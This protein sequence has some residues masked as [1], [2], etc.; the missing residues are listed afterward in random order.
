M[1]K[2]DYG[3]TD[4][5]RSVLSSLIG[6]RLE[7]CLT[8]DAEGANWS[9]YSTFVLRF[10]EEDVEFTTKEVS[11]AG[12]FDETNTVEIFR[13]PD[14]KVWWPVGTWMEV[15]QIDGSTQ[16]VKRPRFYETPIGEVI[17][18]ITVAI[19]TLSCDAS[20]SEHGCD[21]GAIDFV[22][23]VAF[24]FGGSAL[25]FDKGDLSWG[26][27]WRI[28]RCKGDEIEFPCE[29]DDPEQPEFMT[30]VRVEHFGRA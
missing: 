7:A 24:H 14:R 22:R 2:Y 25:V 28:R 12:M 27:D 6:R 29:N 10:A 4:D 9:S 13:R 18:A 21:D 23:A 17:D 30:T 5:M 20:K 16:K 19:G 3:L 1:M 15:R 11:C 26:E 8:T